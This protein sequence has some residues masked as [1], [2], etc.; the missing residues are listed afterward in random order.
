MS[1]L[2]RARLYVRRIPE[3]FMFPTVTVKSLLFYLTKYRFIMDLLFYFASIN[4]F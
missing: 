3:E 2:R 4:V 1:S